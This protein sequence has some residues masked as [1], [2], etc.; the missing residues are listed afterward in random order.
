M[1]IVDA[2]SRKYFT[3]ETS[4]LWDIDFDLLN[5]DHIQKVLLCGRYADDLAQRF[6]YTALSPDKWQACPSIADACEQLKNTGDE[7]LFVATCFSDKG[8]LLAL[9]EKEEV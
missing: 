8:K 5:A 4:W 1:I 3:A 7:H 6:S 9:V 2:V